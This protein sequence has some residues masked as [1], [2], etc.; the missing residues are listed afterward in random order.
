[1]RCLKKNGNP[2]VRPCPMIPRTSAAAGKAGLL[3]RSC[4]TP[5]RPLRGQWPKNV[6]SGTE[7]TATGIVPD[8]HRSSL[9]I[10]CRQ[11]PAENLAEDK[12]RNSRP[13]GPAAAAILINKLSTKAKNRG[14]SVRK[15]RSP[16]KS[17]LRE[18]KV[19]RAQ[20]VTATPGSAP[21]SWFSIPR[22]AP[23]WRT[24]GPS[25]RSARWSPPWRRTTCRR[26]R[27]CVPR[28]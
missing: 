19:A 7:L 12:Y 13:N 27:S 8:S 11:P 4:C 14:G 17:G 15:R 18:K 3:T 16:P 5:S 22:D 2:I 10:S 20:P 21:G 28:R 6:Q 25:G 1:M 26:Q 23:P 9:L 24:R